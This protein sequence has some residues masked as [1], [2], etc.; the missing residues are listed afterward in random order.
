ME[1]FE[2]IHGGEIRDFVTTK[3]KQLSESYSILKIGHIT[4]F[5]E[6]INRS[7][8]ASEAL[9]RFTS[10][11]GAD[12]LPVEGDTGVIGLVH[13][14]DILK[15][16]PG[17]ISDPPIESYIDASSFSIDASENCEKAMGRIL[18]RPRERLY[19]DFMIY[20]RGR[21]FGVGTFA[22]LTRNIAEIR[23]ADM[24]K[25]RN[26]Q[27]F[28]MGRNS[29]SAPGIAVERF[30]GMAQ[31]IGGDYVQCMDLG[32]SLSMLACFDVCG[33]GT[34]AALLTSILSSFFST[35]KVC[36]NLPSITPASLVSTLNKVVMDQTPEEIF[37]A[38]EFLFV[39]RA[40]RQATF[41]NCGS[42]PLYVFFTDPESGKAKGKIIHPN[43]MPLGINE[44]DAPQGSSFPL[45][46]NFR[47]FMYSDGLTDARNQ[48]GELYGDE[49][50]RKFLYPRYLK[51]AP[52]IAGE[53]KTEMKEFIGEAPKA[54]DITALVVE[55][56]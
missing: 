52:D 18:E 4:K 8:R 46:P 11:E 14:A 15:K 7:I 28:L 33:K 44:F 9:A 41:F 21:Y 55:L 30:V 20:E 5:I 53:L 1:E 6:P 38:G 16:K 3:L 39:D 27:E 48:R 26:M 37:V 45:H 34:A 40:K 29:V 35:L 49:R 19:D 17:L 23:N 24:E 51:R 22:D 12:S 43:L 13:K 2:L 25:A 10:S 56:W 50:L 42:P 31:W 32:E 54:D 47:V 36:G